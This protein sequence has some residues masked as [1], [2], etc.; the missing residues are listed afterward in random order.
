[1]KSIS[2][3]WFLRIAATWIV[4]S[5]PL[6]MIQAAEPLPKELAKY[7]SLIKPEHRQHWA[8]LKV[9]RPSVPEVRNTAWVR[10]PIDGFVLARL[11]A[12]GWQPGPA[13]EPREFL[14]RMYLNVIGI[15]P[16]PLE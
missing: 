13:A 3:R 7:E 15:P 2:P 8:F 9:K 12:R 5:A 10:N 16:T 14:R 11:E 1:M 6:S 4:F